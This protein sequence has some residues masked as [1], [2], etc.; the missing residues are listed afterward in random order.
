MFGFG[1]SY[2]QGVP[3]FTLLS[4][5]FFGGSLRGGRLYN[6]HYTQCSSS[7]NVPIAKKS[8]SQCVCV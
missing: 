5:A 2:E 1:I 7:V 8:P 3:L 4:I 6:I